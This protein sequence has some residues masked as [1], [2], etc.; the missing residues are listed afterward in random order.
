MV[1][2]ESDRKERFNQ[3]NETRLQCVLPEMFVFQHIFLK[4][5]I[6]TRVRTSSHAI[7]DKKVRVRE[8]KRGNPTQT[9]RTI[10]HKYKE[11]C[12]TL[13]WI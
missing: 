8:Q 9:G 12:P 7:S 6:K 1:A 13:L 2:D 4:H 5:V 11:Y 10:F 3:Y